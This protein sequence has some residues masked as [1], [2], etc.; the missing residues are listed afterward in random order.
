MCA[1][2]VYDYGL[3]LLDQILQQSGHFLEEFAEMPLPQQDWAMRAENTFIAEQLD[4]DYDLEEEC[5]Q[6][7]LQLMDGNPEQKMAFDMIMS[8]VRNCDGRVFFLN[9]PGGTGKTFVYQT[10][11][12]AVR[13][14][15]WIV[16]C[17]ASTGIA[18]I[19]LPGGRTAHSMFKIP[20][21]GLTDRSLCNINK[22][23]PRAELLRQTRLII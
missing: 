6:H 17:V 23:S 9:G 8:S 15:Q 18:A 16:L 21:E 4:Y 3:Y 7:N 19:L 20:I 14:K 5:A 22:Q 12:H 2:D 13:A 11:C 1:E 10:I